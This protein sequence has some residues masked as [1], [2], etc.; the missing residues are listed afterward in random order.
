[1]KNRFIM[2]TRAGNGSLDDGRVLMSGIEQIIEGLK[3]FAKYGG[4]VRYIAGL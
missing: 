2:P 3:I 4:D 1:M